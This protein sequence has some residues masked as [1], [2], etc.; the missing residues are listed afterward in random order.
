MTSVSGEVFSTI[1]GVGSYLPSR[2]V[3]NADLSSYM[4]T[5]D[6]WIRTRT[7]IEQRHWVEGTTS[8]TDLALEASKKAL[9]NAGVSAQE[10]DLILLATTT[11]DH[12]LPPAACFLQR[13]LGVTGI[14]AMDIRQACASFVY[15]MSIADAFIRVGKYRKVLLVGAET[16]SKALDKTTRGRDV[17]VLFGDGAGACV[18]GATED[19]FSGRIFSTHLHTDG[20]HAEDLWIR[21]PTFA[22]ESERITYGMLEQGDHYPQMDGKTVFINAVKRM[23][24]A[25]EEGLAANGMKLEDIDLFLF[26][27]ANLR[28]NE[29][30]AKKLGVP[31]DKIFNTIQ[32]YGNTTAAT[33]PLGMD[34]AIKAGK[35]KRGMTVAMAAFGSGF[36][37]GSS[38]FKY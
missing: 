12:E 23:P 32:Q 1:L 22:A 11:P 7:G 24:E 16:Q 9:E 21:S 30:V 29:M 14:P 35:L 37:W 27:Q 26:H 13:K 4:D 3:R 8:T 34:A 5:S 33:L 18:I 25:I 2:I 19:P 15:G 31:S 36:S 20:N 28:I 6:E 17:A 10:I 38:I